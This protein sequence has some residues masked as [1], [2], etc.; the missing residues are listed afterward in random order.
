MEKQFLV[1]NVP[2]PGQFYTVQK[3]S[4]TLLTSVGK[5]YHVSAGAKRL[6]LAQ[7]VNAHPLNRKY[8]VKPQSN[9]NKKF[10]PEGIIS[11][12]PIF[13][14]TTESHLFVEKGNNFA[15]IWIPIQEDIAH[16]RLGAMYD[17]PQGFVEH[18]IRH[19]CDDLA[20][21]TQT[22]ILGQVA[23]G[24]KDD[25]SNKDS[26]A[27]VPD[28]SRTPFRFICS[29]FAIFPSP[30]HPDVE[31]VSGPAT[32]TLI[33]N[34][35]VLTAAHVLRTRLSKFDPIFDAR[36]V[37]IAPGNDSLL[38][39]FSDTSKLSL[40]DRVLL[41]LSGAL[42]PFGQFVSRRFS[43]PK[44][45]REG[46]SHKQHLFDYGVIELPTNVGEI[47]IGKRKKQFGF[48]GSRKFGDG[49]I[50]VPQHEK[51]AASTKSVFLSGYPTTHVS[52]HGV[53]QW[54][55]MGPISSDLPVND[56]ITLKRGA[57]RRLGYHIATE[58][59]HSGSPVWNNLRVN[60]KVKRSLLAIHSHGAF[61]SDLAHSGI[62]LTGDVLKQIRQLR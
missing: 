57:R 3:K 1:S 49:T 53:R 22:R 37:L 12:N 19:V 14:R 9:F 15:V 7:K 6:K 41:V 4:S 48:W 42:T 23:G 27:L 35:H 10:F 54:V 33:S 20:A 62:L 8:W 51:I 45:Y 50:L 43:I 61:E 32:G 59:G 21:D 18:A 13:T 52:T 16:E 55:G 5:A 47:T 24:K 2:V 30:F 11:F 40:V 58:D 39:F 17:I 60:G 25:S 29:I 28:A 26:L 36:K 31:L 56:Q 38:N 34:R 46:S 44:E